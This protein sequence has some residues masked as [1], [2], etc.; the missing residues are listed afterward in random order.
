MIGASIPPADVQS[1]YALIALITDPK[2][3]KGWL[4]KVAE[5][6]SDADKVL[7]E[8]NEKLRQADNATLTATTM[9]SAARRDAA[10]AEA[11]KDECDKRQQ[12]LSR[13]TDHFLAEKAKFEADSKAVQA[14]LDTSRRVLTDRELAIT[15]REN[16]AHR[17]AE[18]AQA[19]VKEYDAK[20]ADLKRITG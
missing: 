4:D 7:A 16:S 12:E 19:K 6:K 18:A 5:A 15:E 17:I 9:A 3:A 10:A 20:L 13:Q 8:A 11:L 1:V 2:A 14:T